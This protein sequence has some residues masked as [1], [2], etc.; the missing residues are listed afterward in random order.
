VDS[1]EGELRGEPA[2]L[3]LKTEERR[4]AKT[5]TINPNGMNENGIDFAVRN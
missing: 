3:F 1:S 5:S 4:L 2:I